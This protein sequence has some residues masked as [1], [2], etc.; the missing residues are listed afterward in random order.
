M[1]QRVI[2]PLDGS[3]LS[4]LA[5]EP[6]LEMAKRYHSPLVLLRAYDGPDRVAR[7]L[8]ISQAGAGA[9]PVVMDPGTV[10][11]MT[12]AAEA[13]EADI[14]AYLTGQA[15]KLSDTGLK[16][17]TLAVDGDAADAI[18]NETEREPG[19]LLVMTT[20]GRSG[21]SKLVFG[22]VAQNVLHRAR[23]PVT[24]IRPGQRE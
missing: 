9:A 20:H 14:E 23:V 10:Q 24:V 17:L 19:A 18:V 5:L 16:V 11:S 8:A 7:T 12:D 21:L 15:K 4:E 22:S 6:G 13:G 1:F 2:V 3:P